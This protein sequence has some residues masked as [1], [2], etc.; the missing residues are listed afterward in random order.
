LC[1][2]SPF[3]TRFFGLSVIVFD[4]RQTESPINRLTDLEDKI[5]Q[6]V[7]PNQPSNLTY[8]LPI[9]IVNISDSNFNTKGLD[10]IT[11]K[12]LKFRGKHGYYE[13]ERETGN[14][15]ELDISASGYFKPSI[16]E[17]D[18][19]RTFDYER[20]QEIAAGIIHGT[21]EKLI[22]TLCFNIGE[23]IFEH[24]E[25][26]KRLKVSLRKMNPPVKTPARYAEITMSWKR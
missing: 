3:A 25:Q 9:F 11:I 14:D 15:F 23:Q 26:I 19:N 17:S 8:L 18:L 2:Q 7:F 13:H 10:N 20:A 6:S 4:L 21:S 12:S 24:F 22:E 1:F 16:K 5:G